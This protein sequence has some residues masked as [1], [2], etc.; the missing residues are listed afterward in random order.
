[1]FL[2]CFDVCKM[3]QCFW[4]VTMFLGPKLE[5]DWFRSYGGTIGHRK[6]TETC[7]NDSD[8]FWI[9]G[10]WFRIGIRQGVSFL[11]GITE[12]LPSDFSPAMPGDFLWQIIISFWIKLIISF[13][14]QAISD[15]L[16]FRYV[17]WCVFLLLLNRENKK[18]KVV[19]VVIPLVIHPSSVVRVSCFSCV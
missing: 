8:W 13:D 1:M 10:D 18:C 9:A 17:C 4:N 14:F 3:F 15:V 11:Y 7:G 5:S 12:V 16:L 6:V 19:C 2:K